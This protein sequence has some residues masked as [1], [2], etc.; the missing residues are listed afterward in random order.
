MS[1]LSSIGLI[2]GTAIALFAVVNYAI[3]MVNERMDEVVTGVVKGIPVSAEHRSR[4]LHNQW[5]P[6]NASLAAFV[7]AA[8]I[9]YDR[10]AQ[11][12]SSAAIRSTAYLFAGLSGWVAFMFLILGGSQFLYCLS[13]LREARRDRSA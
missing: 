4:M 1:N 6:Q 2:L 9:A 12:I 10:L 8:A 5:L 3:K 7:L 11:E 13:V